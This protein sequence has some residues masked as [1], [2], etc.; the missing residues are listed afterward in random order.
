MSQL[1]AELKKIDLFAKGLYLSSG[2]IIPIEEIIALES[3]IIPITI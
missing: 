2:E 1:Q 3:D